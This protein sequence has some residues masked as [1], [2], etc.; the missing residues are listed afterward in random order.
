MKQIYI[1]LALLVFS[2]CSTSLSAQ[3]FLS[4]NGK[5]IVNE[6][7]DTIILR[8][9]GLGGWMVQEGYMLQTA[10]FA[11]SQHKIR[12]KIEALMGAEDTQEFYDAWLDNHVRESDI[13]SLKAWG[14]NSVRLPMHYNLYT[15]PIE[16]EPVAGQNTWLDRGFELTDQLIEWCKAKEMYVVLDLHAAPGGQGYDEGI[17]D[18]DPSKPSLWESSQ[19][20]QKT[21]ALWRRIAERYKDEQWVAG[22]DLINEPNWNLPGGTLLRSLY[23][24]IMDAIREVDTKH[25]IFIEGNWFA[26]DFTGLTPPWDD[27]MV[28]SPHKYW[29]YNDQGSIKWVLDLQA[30]HNVPL[31][32]G[33]S[34]ENSNTWFRNA[35]HLMEKNGIGWAW[36]PMKK[37]E[38]IAGPLSITKTPEYEAL[39]NYW[40]NG[41]NVPSA[42]FTKATLMELTQNL[43]IEN[44]FYQ[45]DVVDAMFRQV[46][47]NGTKVFNTQ[48]IPGVLYPTDFDM[49]QSGEAYFDI[50]LAT[51]HVTTSNFTAWNNGWAYRNDGVDIEQ[52]NDPQ[53][54]GFN[55]GWLERGEWM[56]YDVDVEETA[57]YDIK[58]RVATAN[59]GG[60]FYFVADG[61]ELTL[62][63][64]VS[65]T[66]GWQAWN[67]LTI[68]NII[69]DESVQKL[70]FHVNSGGYNLS[71][72]E[73]I[74]KGPT[75]DL[76]TNFFSA[77]TIDNSTVQANINKALIDPL[78]F[79]PTDFEIYVNG[80]SIPINSVNLHPDNKQL[81]VFDVNHNFSPDETIKIS[82]FGT[83]INAQD[84][85]PLNVFIQK[86]VDN[87]V[88]IVHPIP[89]LVEAEDYFLEAGVDTENTFDTGGG[90]NLGNLDSG[91]YLDYY[92]KA[93]VGGTYQASYRTAAESSSG[94]L[95]LQ[96][97]HPDG[98]FT[99]LHNA[100]FDP[101]GDWQTWATT[102]DTA[103]FYL[104]SGEHHIR[105]RIVNP[106]FNLNWMEFE[107]IAV[108]TEEI[109]ANTSMTL[110]PNPTVG[111]FMLEAD[112]YDRQDATVHLYSILGQK[113]KT[114]E[115]SEI[116]QIQELLDVSDL[117]AGN[118]FL[119]LSLENGHTLSDQ[120]IKIE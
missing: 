106:A 75:T 82:Y 2:V 80:T 57:V 19:N 58:V 20:Q 66:G 3:H 48:S 23:G 15:L 68:S 42:A 92:I 87:R 24:Q 120:I 30:E 74:K 45:K 119:H 33:E 103:P 61:A 73:F 97:V 76:S 110:Y 51:Y 65:S 93:D 108:P 28:Y 21:V 5:A 94:S 101:T 91:D 38:S 60:S 102:D 31:Y 78:T 16:E 99:P 90:K 55:V 63:Y 32:F 13:D 35:I 14:F 118:Y 22:Y 17:S 72:I 104:S 77:H 64:Y 41:G 117:P 49:G 113:V 26:N 44:C 56:Q 54:N 107:L 84:G 53:G 83:Q 36:W 111:Q 10:A 8:G 70:Q 88:P 86:N 109:V 7:G 50:N 95:Q 115:F 52:S 37:I 9:M 114:V 89:G 12:A 34:G 69:L 98:T 85:S 79:A 96:L 67:D 116:Q 46:S 71:T 40:N 1:L 43:Q 62:P 29:S 4:T 47:S 25:M 18:Y 6:Q 11:N 27:N 39:L 105:V 81:I 59:G 112:L 100:S